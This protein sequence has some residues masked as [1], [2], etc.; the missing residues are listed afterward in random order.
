MH[1][2]KEH[3]IFSA[4]MLV[5]LLSALSVFAFDSKDEG[6]ANISQ[7]DKFPKN[8]IERYAYSKA[9]TNHTSFKDELKKAKNDVVP[10]SNDEYVTYRT[11]GSKATGIST[12]RGVLDSYIYTEAKVVVNRL[13]GNEARVI[14]FG[15]PYASISSYSS[16]WRG[17]FNI[18]RVSDT[19][20][21]FSTTG[22]FIIHG[23]GFTV[24]YSIISVTA[25]TSAVTEVMT[26]S[27][28]IK[29]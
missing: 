7:I 13:T 9:V 12:N 5:V 11:K 18:N 17:G 14:D 15:A 26:L 1:Y 19:S 10:L 16:E 21:R 8:S 25:N 6:E 20:A 4:V 29:W 2:E 28:T 23:P 24:G 27:T 22:Q 3:C